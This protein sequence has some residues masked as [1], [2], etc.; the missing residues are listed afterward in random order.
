MRHQAVV[1]IVSGVAVVAGAA[2]GLYWWQVQRAPVLPAHIVNIS[3]RV[4]AAARLP[5]CR[6][7]STG[8]GVGENDCSSST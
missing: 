4:E 1:W 8:A 5:A 3:G 6:R 7:S 2:A